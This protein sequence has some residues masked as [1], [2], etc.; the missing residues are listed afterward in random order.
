M[1]KIMKNFAERMEIK[2]V[3]IVRVFSVSFLFHRKR[4]VLYSVFILGT[5]LKY[6][7]D[8]IRLKY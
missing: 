6:T 2:L 5:R 8:F 3:L 4:I 1:K 7:G